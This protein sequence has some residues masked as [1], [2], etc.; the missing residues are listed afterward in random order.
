MGCAEAL[1][2]GWRLQEGTDRIGAAGRDGRGVEGLVL[3]LVELTMNFGGGIRQQI[4]R[5]TV[6]I[7]AAG[8]APVALGVSDTAAPHHLS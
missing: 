6:E 7:G 4:L 2:C 3:I 1:R 5:G 8:G